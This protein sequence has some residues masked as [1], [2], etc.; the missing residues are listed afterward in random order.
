MEY[1]N[2]CTECLFFILNINGT[3]IYQHASYPQTLH[4]FIRAYIMI[5]VV[6]SFVPDYK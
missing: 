4:A 1:S 3:Q 5:Q 6:S 2:G